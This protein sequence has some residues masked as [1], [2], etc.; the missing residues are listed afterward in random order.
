MWLRAL[1]IAFA[2]DA[3]IGVVGGMVRASEFDTEP[4]L[5]FE[6]FY[7]GFTKSFRA[8]EWGHAI[9]A[10]DDPMFIRWATSVRAAI[11]PYDDRLSIGWADSTFDLV[12]GLRRTVVRI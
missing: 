4:Q 7:G 2:R 9:S 6:E 12:P 3:E 11:W 5:S 8:K 1:G 10:A